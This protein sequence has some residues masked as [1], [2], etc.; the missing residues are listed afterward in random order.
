MELKTE[1]IERQRLIE[2]FKLMEPR[3]RG[4]SNKMKE[5]RAQLLEEQQNVCFGPLCNGTIHYIAMFATGRNSNECKKCYSQKIINSYKR[6]N[7]RSDQRT[8]YLLK[9]RSIM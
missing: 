2:E 8:K 3:K 1:Y 5:L 7:G 6:N 4:C 9:K